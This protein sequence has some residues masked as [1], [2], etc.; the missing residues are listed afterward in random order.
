MRA[1]VVDHR[2][3]LLITEQCAERRHSFEPFTTTSTG[4]PAAASFASLASAGQAP[5]PTAPCATAM[6]QPSHTVR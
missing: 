5:A 1:D 2:C 6:W 4:Y 3:H